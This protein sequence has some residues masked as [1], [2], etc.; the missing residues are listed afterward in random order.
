VLCAAGI[1]TYERGEWEEV[2]ES[3]IIG[4]FKIS[5]IYLMSSGRK[6]KEGDMVGDERCI[7]Y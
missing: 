7:Q 6:V 2:G 5:T 1:W 4:S 3:S